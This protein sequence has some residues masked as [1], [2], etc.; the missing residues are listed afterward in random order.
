MQDYLAAIA[1][2]LGNVLSFPNILI[3]VMGTL[4]AMLA[5]FLP[6]IGNA[7][8]ATLVLVATLSWD[9]VSVLLMF[10]ALTGGATFMGSITAILFN[11]PGN[12]SSAAV[13]L[14]GHPMARNGEAR[15]AIA[16]AATASAIGSLFGVM[17][18]LAILPVVQ[19]LL[20][21]FGPL[22]RVLLGIWGLSTIVAIPNS[23]PSRAIAVT[24]LGLLCAMIGSDPATGLP[25]WTFGSLQLF[26]GFGT[27][28]VL[29]GFFTLSEIIGWRQNLRISA[30]GADPSGG[31]VRLGIR[32]VLGHPGL[33]AR[34]SV[35]GTLVGVIPGVG[36]T[37]SSF[38]SYGQAVQW[39]KNPERFGTGDV[40]GVIAP[41]AAVDSKDGGSLLPVL[42]FGLPGSEGG[43]ILVT[44]LAIHGLVPGSPML[45]EDLPLSLTLIFAL[46]MSNIL[47]SIVG[48][49]LAPW[50]ARLTRLRIDRIA[51]PALIASLVTIVQLNGLLADLYVAVGFGLLGYLLRLFGWPRVPF[52]IAFILGAFIESN[53][54]LTLRLA[55]VGR[56][57][58]W[59]QPAAVIIVCL[60]L[61]SSVW[62]LSGRKVAPRRKPR[63]KGPADASLA[64]GLGLCVLVMAL[65]TIL[66]EGHYSTYARILVWATTAV[67]GVI[68]LSSFLRVGQTSAP[69]PAPD[70][71]DLWSFGL[72]A[73]VPFS[74]VLVGLPA[75]LAMLS[76]VW[77]LLGSDVTRRRLLFVA[78]LSGLVF[79][80][81]F[82]VIGNLAGLRLPDPFL[83]TVLEHFV[84]Q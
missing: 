76:L 50:L 13:L 71:R 73:A 81:V 3:P 37:V 72:L 64:F 40:R 84:A 54:A 39:S 2:G 36:G 38:V 19:P 59:E 80:G 62:M 48:V 75:A 43:V 77:L 20:L 45:T 23:S 83:V 11:I 14:D 58:F 82:H 8:L 33:T 10:G 41:E 65:A 17:V 16:C 74:T 68:A 6:G 51:L 60:I 56:I 25:R 53:L 66:G 47:T 32:A 28:A 9:P 57:S 78:G 67:Y 4:I 46:L 29:L 49:S 30:E 1:I 18:L 5:S 21:E 24:L 44:V 12:A 26:D 79:A 61:G 7:S 27:I 31:S 55:E 42:A 35:I 69:S 70:G 63:M 15:T 22:E 52:I 34:S